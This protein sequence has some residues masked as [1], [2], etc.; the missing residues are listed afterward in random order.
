MAKPYTLDEFEAQRAHWARV[1]AEPIP[2]R[3]PYRCGHE[4]VMGLCLNAPDALKGYDYRDCAGCVATRTRAQAR[5]AAELGLPQLSGSERQVAWA[6]DLRIRA[7]D[8]HGLRAV[9]VAVTHEVESTWWIAN[10][11]RLPHLKIFKEVVAA[12]PVTFDSILDSLG[13]VDTTSARRRCPDNCP[14]CR[15]PVGPPFRR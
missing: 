11:N 14:A 1:A 13:E 3:V 9:I 15:K 2:V 7:V 10:R 6:N 8:R 5:R 12:R 4:E